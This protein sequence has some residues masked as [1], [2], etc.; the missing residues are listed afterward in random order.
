M[1][2]R[3]STDV[4]FLFDHW[5]LS[6]VFREQCIYGTQESWM[7][8]SNKYFWKRKFAK[9]VKYFSCVKFVKWAPRVL[10]LALLLFFWGQLNGSITT[11]IIVRGVNL[12]EFP[13]PTKKN[14]FFL[15]KTIAQ[16]IVPSLKGCSF[17][18]KIYEVKLIRLKRPLRLNVEP[19]RGPFLT[20]PLAPGGKVHPFIPPKG[21]QSLLFRKIEGRTENF[22]PMG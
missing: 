8:S 21:E 5:D 11:K 9:L 19:C 1:N 17:R 20:S 15:K 13:A 18:C 16:W 12:T 3:N 2:P 22:T 7:K 4:I 14:F 6:I 10:F